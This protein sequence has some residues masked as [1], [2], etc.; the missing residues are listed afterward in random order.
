MPLLLL[1]L[2]L[3]S[4]ENDREAMLLSVCTTTFTKGV[5]AF[6]DRKQA[7]HRMY[8]C[9]ALSCLALFDISLC[10]GVL[11]FPAPVVS[12]RFLLSL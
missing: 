3:Q 6:F 12:V 11:V 4:R 2:L 7:A 8:V 10:V 9:V 5:I 1:L